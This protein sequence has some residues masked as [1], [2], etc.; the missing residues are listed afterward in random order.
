M[1]RHRNICVNTE[2]V[3]NSA[4][5]RKFISN[6]HGTSLGIMHFITLIVIFTIIII[7]YLISIIYRRG[8]EHEESFFLFLFLFSLC[9]PLDLVR[10]ISF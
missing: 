4:T 9:V 3:S 8:M 1:S 2:I 5:V 10:I 6:L 7:S